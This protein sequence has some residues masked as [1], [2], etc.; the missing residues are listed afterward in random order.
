MRHRSAQRYSYDQP[1]V[2]VVVV[3]EDA[4]VTVHRRGEVT[5]TTATVT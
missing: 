5:L 3:S 4:P 1:D 2:T